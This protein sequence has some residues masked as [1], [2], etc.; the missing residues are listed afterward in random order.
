MAKGLWE[1][2]LGGIG[3][4]IDDARTKLIDEAWFGRRSFS[5]DAGFEPPEHPSPDDHEP[6]PM[7]YLAQFEEFWAPRE[8]SPEPPAPDLGIER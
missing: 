2:V 7:D 6:S 5:S 1:I 8:P 4:A 3:G